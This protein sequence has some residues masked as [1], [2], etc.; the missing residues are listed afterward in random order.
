MQAR[1]KKQG[2]KRR[3][4]GVVHSEMSAA[5]SDME[6][7]AQLRA[8]KL[9]LSQPINRASTFDVSTN[10]G[11][12]A[13]A[14]QLWLG[15]YAESMD[16]VRSENAALL[17]V[18]QAQV[19]NTYDADSRATIQHF[20]RKQRQVNGTLLNIL[21]TQSKFNVP[22][23]S[24]GLS[25][26]SRAQRT[27]AGAHDALRY[28]FAGALMTTTFTEDVMK[29]A[30]SLRPPNPEQPLKDTAV[31]VFDNLSMKMNYGSYV[32][33]LAKAGSERI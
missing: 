27:S 26:M 10:V 8:W 4:E 25:I 19:M 5:I 33:G 11:K 16:M 9:A 24:A 12:V 18:L 17:E 20:Q 28:F 22:L 14:R 1:S 15:G 7:L 13:L 29:I 23:I 21:R 6:E 31:G 32:R 2:K 30:R 3:L